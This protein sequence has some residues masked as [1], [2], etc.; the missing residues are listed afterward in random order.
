MA[1][2]APWHCRTAARTFFGMSG[3]HHSAAF[4]V[5]LATFA[6]LAAF[7]QPATAVVHGITHQREA[8]GAARVDVVAAAQ[9]LAA[10]A[11][12]ASDR[13]TLGASDDLPAEHPVL[14]TPTVAK[15]SWS[16]MPASPAMPARPLV[17]TT[18][19]RAMVS[20]RAP[21]AHPLASHALLP[22]QPRAPPLG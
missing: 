13:A 20:P 11:A 9:S 21:P 22:D 14:H 7:A 18:V 8:T 4:R 3:A 10:G 17:L 15:L 12:T 2:V 19:P 16:P 6:L 5:I 1:G